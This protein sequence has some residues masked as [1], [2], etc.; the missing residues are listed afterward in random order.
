MIVIKKTHCEPCKEILGLMMKYQ[1]GPK[2]IVDL[3]RGNCAQE[4][5]DEYNKLS[6]DAKSSLIKLSQLIPQIK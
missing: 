6:A 3:T 1:I 2:E 4:I 5:S